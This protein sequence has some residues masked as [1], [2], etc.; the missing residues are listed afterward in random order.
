MKKILGLSLLFAGLV[1]VKAQGTLEFTVSLNGAN[2]VPPTDS[3]RIGSGNLSLNGT[4]LDYTVAFS[5]TADV[6]TDVTIN[7]PANTGSTAPILFDLGAPFFIAPNP[8]ELPWAVTGTINNLTSTQIDDL[9]AGLW[10]VNVLSS[11]SSYPGGEIRGQI[12]PVPEPSATA[13]LLLGLGGLTWRCRRR[14]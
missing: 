3:T 1:G 6:P 4:A 12:V 14:T 11:P 8:P 9:L 7:G 2:E 10:Y 13:L 5:A